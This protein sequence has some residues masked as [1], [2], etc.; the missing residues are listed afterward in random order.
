MDTKLWLQNLKVRWEYN[1][2][3][4]LKEIRWEIVDWINVGQDTDQ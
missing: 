4:D 1:I 2:R 3:T